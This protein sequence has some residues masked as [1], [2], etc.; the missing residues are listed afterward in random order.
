MNVKKVVSYLIGALLGAGF[1]AVVAN[2]FF[3]E[4]F[5]EN[6]YIQE[7][8]PFNTKEP[9]V[10]VIEAPASMKE[11][12]LKTKKKVKYID[13]ST[14]VISP[15][16]DVNLVAKKMLGKRAL[17]EEEIVEEEEPSD[18]NLRV[19]SLEEFADPR[20]RYNK[21][22]L[23]Y[24]SEDDILTNDNGDIVQDADVLLGDDGLLKFGEGSDDPDSV[25]IRNDDLRMDYEVVRLYTSY[26]ESVLNIKEKKRPNKTRKP[27]KT[28]KVE[29]LDVDEEEG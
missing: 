17:E 22:V 4:K 3:P 20:N 13:Y 12:I 14:A 26:S 10:E 25:Y 15:K 5:E 7:E 6:D 29:N 24:Y 9:P 1:G 21:E 27:A 2:R 23:T 28:R 19:I 11:E 18:T 8:L 16:E